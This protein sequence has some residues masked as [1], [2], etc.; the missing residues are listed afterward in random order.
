MY[1]AAWQDQPIKWNGKVWSAVSAPVPG[2]ASKGYQS[3]LTG[4]AC[5][6]VKH[7]W[8]VAYYRRH[9]GPTFNEEL[10][11]TGQTGGPS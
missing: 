11:L 8:A 2:P 6:S 10:S 3:R 7:C 1:F 4:V 9:S 5:P